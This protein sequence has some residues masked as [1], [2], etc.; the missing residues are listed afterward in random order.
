MERSWLC[1]RLWRLAEAERSES[2]PRRSIALPRRSAVG[3]EERFPATRLSAG[4][5]VRKETITG[6]RCNGRDAPKPVVP[7]SVKGCELARDQRTEFQHPAPHRF[8]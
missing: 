5:G 8:I 3:H 2:R 1:E 6:T 7:A 4:Y